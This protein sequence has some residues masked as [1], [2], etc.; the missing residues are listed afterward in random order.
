MDYVP[1]NILV[2]GG[3]GFIASNLLNYLMRI[4]SDCYFVNLDKMDYC[5]DEKNV[6]P[7]ANYKLIE[8][9]IENFDIVYYILKEYQIDTVIHMAAQTHVDNSFGNSIQFTKTNVM[10]THIML[11]ACR[12]Y[13]KIRKFIHFSTDEVMGELKRDDPSCEENHLLIPNNPY[14]ASKA[15]A[16]FIVFSYYRSFKIPI[17]ITRCNNVYGPRQYPEKVVP[18]FICHLLKK[19]KCPIQGKGDQLRTFIYVDDVCSAVDVIV[20]KGSIGEIYHIGTDDEYS[21]LDIGQILVKEIVDKNADFKD[22]SYFIEDRNF[23]DFRYSI[24]VTKL[25]KLGWK[26]KVDFAEGIKKTIIWYELFRKK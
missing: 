15:G 14:A 9:N 3:C 8:G 4:Y 13:G 1:K 11:E 16:E 21:V 26:T 17:I 7:S 2:T 23:N 18:K 24:D 22:H 6:N 10:G 19:E 5:A 12:R 25:G 20:K